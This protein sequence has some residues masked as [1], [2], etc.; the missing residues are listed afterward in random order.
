MRATLHKTTMEWDSTTKMKFFRKNR[1]RCL[2]PDKLIMRAVL[3]RP[4]VM[5][6]SISKLTIGA[7]IRSL[8]QSRLTETHP[9]WGLL[10]LPRVPSS[11]ARA[12]APVPVRTP[13]SRGIMERWNSSTSSIAGIWNR[14]MISL[15]HLSRQSCKEC[16]ITAQSIS[17]AGIIMSTLTPWARETA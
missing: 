4:A 17:S 2:K 12:K 13:T 1:P 7:T 6:A 10:V 11:Q 3:A 9:T 16:W 8:N 15:Q 14:K 5:E